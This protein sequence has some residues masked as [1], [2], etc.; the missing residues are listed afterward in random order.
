M[1]PILFID[2]DG[3]IIEEPPEDFQVDSLQKLRFLP[4]VLRNLH[5]IR[6]LGSFEWVMVSNQ[7]GL[8]TPSFPTADFE[9]PHQKML[10]ILADEQIFFDSIFI[11]KTF[12]HQQSPTRKPGTAMLTGYIDKPDYDMENSFVIGD[13]LSDMQLALNL[14][15]KGIWIAHKPDYEALAHYLKQSNNKNLREKFPIITQDWD[16][17]SNFLLAQ[18]AAKAEPVPLERKAHISRQ[19]HETTIN[20]DLNLDGSGRSNI[21]TGVGFL[22]HMLEQLAYH[23]KLDLDI[24]CIGDLHIDAHHSIED[25]AIALGESFRK[26]LGD[27]RGIARYGFFALV[28]DESLARVSL[29]FSG[30]PYLTWQVDFQESMLG[31]MPT[32]MF[33]HFFY[34]FAVHAQTSLHICVEGENAH[35]QIEAVFKAFAKS[36]AIAKTIESNRIASTKGVL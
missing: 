17:I 14:G 29:D 12:P 36:V 7:D 22:D 34:S 21:T 9:A 18:G 30:R 26:A 25:I 20:I 33:K 27:K 35:H 8:G 11:D 2:R 15:C 6:H 3:T 16:E 32:S 4:K 24:S 1:K 31:T 23:G 28:M 13:R 5:K 19:T 10:N